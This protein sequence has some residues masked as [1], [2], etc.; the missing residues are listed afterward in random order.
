LNITGVCF[1]SV[2]NVVVQGN[3]SVA[4]GALLDDITAGDPTSAPVVSATVTVGGNVTVGTGGVLLLG[5]SPNITC[6][7]PP[8]ITYGSIAGNLT[9]T[10]AQGVV[11]HSIAVGGNVS[12]SGGGGGAAAVTCNAQVPG[13]PTVT[14]LEPWSLDPTLDYTPVYTDIEDSSIGGSLQISNL[15]SC[16]LGSL[17][18]QIAGSATWFNNTMGDPDAMEVGSNLIFGNMSCSLN[19]PAIQFGDGGAAPSVV[20]LSASGQCAFNVTVLNPAPEA[21]EGPGILEHVTTP[22]SSFGGTFIGTFSGTPEAALSFG[23]TSAGNSL[24][25]ELESF[26]LTGA[27]INGSGTYN[28]GEPAGSTGAAFLGTTLP[29]GSTSFTVFVNCNCSF[30][31]ETGPITLRAYGTT[32]PNGITQ[33]TF[34]ITSGGGAAPGS[35]T[36]LAG[37]GTFS[38]FGGLSGDVQLTEHL[39]L[40]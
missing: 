32:S 22:A 3:L 20:G 31:G 39:K 19:T 2:G 14:N 16:W 36:T 7:S 4:P 27:G 40:T 9:A 33:G 24:F 13:A 21:G 15:T 35:L 12:I 5:C 17:R 1:V 8:G 11:L 6:T 34:L 18:D 29:N 38:N 30:Q 10:G 28:P 23:T 37:W 26:T 25:G